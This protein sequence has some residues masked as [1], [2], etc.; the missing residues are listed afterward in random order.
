ME[1]SISEIITVVIFIG[2]VI[3]VWANTKVKIARIETTMNL[4]ITEIETKLDE[5]KKSS[6]DSTEKFQKENKEEHGEILKDI[7]SIQR[8]INDINLKLAKQ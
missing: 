3:M 4:K 6:N 7:K 8:S 2:S 1:F 5:N